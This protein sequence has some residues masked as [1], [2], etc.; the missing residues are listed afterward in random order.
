MI[1][2]NGHSDKEAMNE[3]HRSFLPT[4]ICTLA[5]AAGAC[6]SIPE[7]TAAPREAVRIVCIGDSLTAC[8][9]EGGRYTNWLAEWLPG[10]TISCRT[11]SRNSRI[12]GGR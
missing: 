1:T 12:F 7:N 3:T 9:G 5:L 4:A 8:G 11:C 10:C 2:P 6:I